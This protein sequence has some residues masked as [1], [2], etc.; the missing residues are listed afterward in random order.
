[1]TQLGGLIV[2]TALSIRE[3]DSALDGLARALPIEVTE[4][5]DRI[6]ITRAAGN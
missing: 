6:V 4:H 2:Y 5:Y 3:I 1:M